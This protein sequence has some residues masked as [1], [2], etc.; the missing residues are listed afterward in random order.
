MTLGSRVP[1]PDPKYVP[2]TGSDINS[3]SRVRNQNQ[4]QSKA[5]LL[6][7]DITSSYLEPP[8]DCV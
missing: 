3:R 2:V 1:T 6:S 5:S 7:C 8:A 4:L